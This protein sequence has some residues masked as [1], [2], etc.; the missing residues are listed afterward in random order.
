MGSDAF[1]KLTLAHNEG[2]PFLGFF[3]NS[4]EDK[5]FIS[6]H[7]LDPCTLQNMPA[8]LPGRKSSLK[9]YILACRNG[10]VLLC[11]NGHELSV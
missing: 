3:T 4:S 10:W 9:T 8:I 1:K 7:N 11:T 6:D 2:M 5:R